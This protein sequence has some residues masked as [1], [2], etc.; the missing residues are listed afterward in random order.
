MTHVTLM[1][2]MGD[3]P[4]MQASEEKASDAVVYLDAIGTKRT[5]PALADVVAGVL[6]EAYRFACY[7]CGC[8]IVNRDIRPCARHEKALRG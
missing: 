6:R 5:E 8:R 1:L 2:D 3:E 4:E 7:E